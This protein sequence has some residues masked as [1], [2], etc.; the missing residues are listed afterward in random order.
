MKRQPEIRR[1]AF[2]TC[3][4]IAACVFPLPASAV[5]KASEQVSAFY[6]S[7]NHTLPVDVPPFRGLEPSLALSYS[8]E[9]RNGFVGTGWTLSGFGTIQRA[10]AGLGTPKFDANDVFLLDGQE[11]LPC[12]AAATSPGC[13]SGGTHATKI[14]SYLKIKFDSS[15]NSWTVFAKDGTRTVYSATITVPPN[16]LSQG[17]TMRWGVS[18]RVDTS[19]NTVSYGWSCVDGDCYPE[20]VTY[21]GYQVVFFKE[22]RPDWLSWAA[23]TTL[24]ETRYRLRSIIVWMPGVPA[25]IRGYRLGYTTSPLTGRSLLGSVQQY[26][27]DL[28]HDGAGLFT[29]GTTLPAQQFTYQ[30]D[31]DG[32][33]FID[34]SAVTAPVG[35]TLPVTWANLVNA[36]GTGNGNSLLKTGGSASA[37]DA[38]ADSTYAIAS[39]NGHVQWVSSEATTDGK[40]AGLSNGNSDA[41]FADID[42]AMQEADDGKLYVVDHGT[43]F[44]PW[45]RAAGDVLR[46]E[47]ASGIVYFK[48]NG[49]VL[50][51][52]THSPTY[53]LRVDAS[54]RGAQ[55]TLQDVV[56][57]GALVSVNAWCQARLYGGDFNGD[58]R[59]DQLCYQTTGQATASVA[60]SSPSG[61]LPPVVWLTDS[62]PDPVFADFN[63]DGKTDIAR[64]D[65]WTGE[66]SVSISSGTSFG[67]F[68]PW[69]VAQG[70]GQ[71]G[72]PVQCRIDPA[73]VGSGDFNGDGL[74]DVYCKLATTD[75]EIVGL[76]NG[77]AFSFSVFSELGCDPAGDT[78]SGAV[79]FDG[80]GKDDWFCIS[81]INTNTLL[82]FPST[83]SSFAFPAHGGLDGTFCSGDGYVL[84]D[85]NADGRTDATCT[86]NGKVA[87]STGRGFR[88]VGAWGGWCG[89]G[90]V[91]AADVDGDGASELVCDNA[92]AGA[93]D[94][95][96]RKWV[97]TGQAAALSAAETWKASW[98]A[99]DLRMGDWNG[100]GKSD[101]YCRSLPLPAV[102]GT[103]GL[104]VDA[105]STVGNGL[106][107]SMTVGYAPSTTFPQTNNPGPRNVVV[108]LRLDDGKGASATT[109]FEY[110]GGYIDR[111]ARQFLGFRYA[112]SNLPC[113][114]GESP[115]PYVETWFSQ[116]LAS[117]GMTDKILRRRGDGRILAK[118]AFDYQT[119]GNALPRVA[120][121]AGTTT[122]AYPH[123][124]CTAESCSGAAT[125]TTAYTY[126]TF[127]N[128]TRSEDR[129]DSSTSTDDRVTVLSYAYNTSAWIVDRV[130][131]TQWRNG[132]GTTLAKTRV[133]YDLQPWNAPPVR[134]LSTT[135][136][137][138]LEEEFRWIESQTRYSASGN[139]IS[140]KDATQV[141]VTTT[142]DTTHD[143]YPKK[144]MNPVAPG[145]A[146]ELT[147][148]PV[149]GAIS[150]R[151]DPDAK[152]TTFQ[153]DAL[154]RLS[155]ID[156]PATGTP[157][158][159]GFE[160][161]FY[162]D[163][164]DPNWQRVVIE[165]PAAAAGANPQFSATHFDGLER[166]YMTVASG[167]NATVAILTMQGYD[168][169][170]SLAWQTA[171]FYS[172]DPS[173]VTTFDYDALDRNTAV[174]PPDGHATTFLHDA[175]RRTTTDANGRA[176]TEDYDAFG[177][178]ALVERSIGGQPVLTRYTYDALGRMTRLADPLD[179]EF[180]WRFDSMG[181]AIEQRDPASGLTTFRFDDAGRLARQ[182]DAKG[183]LSVS[184]YDAVGRLASQE[185][186]KADLTIED[187]I[188]YTYGEARRSYFNTGLLTTV[189]GPG[190]TVLQHDYD[191]RGREAQTRRTLDGS[192]YTMRRNYDAAGRLLSLDYPGYDAVGPYTYDA[193]GRLQSIAGVVN[194]IM[195]DASSRPLVQA[196]ANGTTT[197]R[198]YDPLSRQLTA[199][200]T[201]STSAR[202]PVLQ[203]VVYTP[204][205]TGRVSAVSSPFAGE[206]WTYSYDDLYRLTHA[207]GSTED[208]HWTYDIGGR[209]LHNSR[210]GNY[211][212]APN[213]YA[214]LTAGSNAYAYDANG[215]MT[216]GAGRT[217]TWNAANR[218]AQINGSQYRYDADGERLSASVGGSMTRYPFG[219][220]LEIAN[221]V[222]TRYIDAPG[223]GTVAKRV[224][225]LGTSQT[226]WLHADRQGSIQ[227]VSDV[228]G[229]DARR[230]KYR[231]YGEL[232]AT[233]SS[234]NESLGWIGEREDADTG[235]KY[236]HARYYDPALSTFVS[237][238]DWHPAIAGVGPN[239]YSYGF[240]DPIN[241]MDPT[242]HM[243]DCLRYHHVHAAKGGVM[244]CQEVCYETWGGWTNDRQAGSGD[245]PPPPR[246]TNPRGGQGGYPTLPCR[247][248]SCPI[249]PPP[250]C[251]APDCTPAPSEPDPPPIEA[252][253]Q[254]PEPLV[255]SAGGSPR[256]KDDERSRSAP[257]VAAMRQPSA[258]GQDGQGDVWKRAPGTSRSPEVATVAAITGATSPVA[259]ARSRASRDPPGSKIAGTMH[260][261]DWFRTFGGSMAS[262]ITAGP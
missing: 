202:S 178:L 255:E 50:R 224:T 127:G 88:E 248:K 260:P 98:C 37:W 219:K 137:R 165:T 203:N 87:L 168:A 140:V 171:P 92:G 8:S 126:D 252:I 6:G 39:G 132:S 31:A 190:T 136:E 36:A 227:S 215:N 99:G 198:T 181:R 175:R 77:S 93:N 258:P 115:C 48:K 120:L 221:G 42:Y 21:N 113:I 134:G 155:R 25:H 12:Q 261:S 95:Q 210:V 176:T 158:V 262:V 233:L 179:I 200:S 166:T 70:T 58:G 254:S 85:L 53:P 18:S 56:L 135:N 38:G 195:W 222:V 60:L 143:L 205:A 133:R 62:L 35:T 28:V 131:E 14:E 199:I 55:A 191:A 196:N 231:P 51:Q 118:S 149:C 130:A 217:I 29:G 46:V 22:Q 52:S 232:I 161:R 150:S 82:I 201:L 145:E 67:A 103:G 19:G 182:T 73:A 119:N 228:T 61:L 152:L 123:D 160:R 91:S 41:S 68:A 80:D 187:T 163:F 17:G 122:V 101:L 183:Q 26:G 117:A 242:G 241:N 184:T 249:T 189:T 146:V 124:G 110:A 162:R 259:N 74:V 225:N 170:G 78:Q 188:T 63:G 167:P 1:H 244:A 125:S 211:T 106:G 129:G 96:V 253:A 159:A 180:Q 16:A 109:R 54:L 185:I 86:G 246:N 247:G 139:V 169:R 144:V 43:T 230:K 174:R 209:I 194:S 237:A 107:G 197:Q 157:A 10:N 251:N 64:H 164:G 142:Y 100:D 97:G 108:S 32:R 236:L 13:A 234:F 220:S 206:S 141:E 90:N 172:T 40:A 148:D 2:A 192:V 23:A 105:A 116:Q 69:G 66:F 65:Q 47:V 235:L 214:A 34:W 71:N 245:S 81:A 33:K 102:A 250:A 151:N 7:F 111:I 114:A 121:L 83:G 239:R 49:I 229:T 186:R 173:Q 154:C 30:I 89:G 112:R 193:A 208:Q 44:G 204:D 218:I 212:Y 240:G 223:I 45:D 3:A 76:S 84:A 94:I 207:I 213:N 243:S 177:Q 104:L 59:S 138:W 24:G 20:T 15:T 256:G 75:H 9:G 11:L 128:L 257:T 147:W 156:Y 238:D 226:Y 216:S 72:Q 27:K 79:D 5:E 153:T 4:L 57:T